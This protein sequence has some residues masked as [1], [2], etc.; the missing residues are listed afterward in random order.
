MNESSMTP[1][2][3]ALMNSAA[4]LDLSGRARIRVTGEDRARLL[5][6]MTTNHVQ[7]MKPGDGL[8]AYFLNAQ[9]RILAD[10][11]VFCFE[12]H[13]LLDTEPASRKPVLEHLD[14]YIIADDVTLQDV[15]DETF[16]FGIEGPKATEVAATAGL[17]APHHRFSHVDADGYTV[18]AISSTGLYGV[19]I[20]GPLAR[21]EE[22]ATAIEGA[23]A[24]A[25]SSE[26]AETARIENFVPKYG[27]DITEHTLPQ[28]TQQ[29]HALHFQK[30]CYL[31]QEIVE[32]IRSRGHVNKVL[33]GFRA[34]SE[35]VPEPG[36]K[37][38]LEGNPA[39]E[40]TSATLAEGSVFGLAY[41]RVP[42]ARSGAM[43][44]M[45]GVAVELFAPRD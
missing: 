36:S 8:Y 7:Q 25:A 34:Q 21:K 24:I 30:G 31:G 40:V 26:D 14:H 11:Y 17:P 10:V 19:R 9:G 13:F 4:L 42:G 29:L 45:D 37:L 2:Y 38:L 35:R 6:A 12:D 23:G 1:G 18:A 27:C 41:V 16:S 15:T 43:A 32:R 44:E 3:K 33:M 39:G 5:H 28:E 22:L 20:T